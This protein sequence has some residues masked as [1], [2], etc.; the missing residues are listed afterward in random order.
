ML[1]RQLS[2]LVVASNAMV[3]LSNTHQIPPP[4]PITSQDEI[5]Q[6]IGGFNR[7]I[8]IWEQ[9][10]AALREN[11]LRFSEAERIAHLGHWQWDLASGELVCS[12]EVF[13]I[14]E[15]NPAA[16]ART[17]EALLDVIHPDDR[18]EVNRA[19][20]RSLQTRMPYEISHRIR[21]RDGRIKWVYEKCSSDFDPA[22]K[23]LRSMGAMQDITERKAMEDHIRQLAFYDELTGLPNRRLLNDRLRQT[24]AVSKRSGLHGAL[25]FL[26]LDNFKPINDAHGHGIGDLL[27]MEVAR[28]LTECVREVDTVARLGGDEFVVMISELE[29]DKATATEQAHSVAEKILASLAAPYELIATQ[30]GKSGRVVEHRCSASIGVVLFVNHEVGEDELMGHADTAMYQAKKAGRNVVRFYEA[31]GPA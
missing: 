12:D 31:D 22:G 3:T 4:L 16:F 13:R 26:D 7:L 25:M 11:Q 6:L 23:P 24:M 27:L 17:H 10:E 14:L 2:P 30:A 29:L 8:E 18:D 20:A 15:I 28:R 19:Y 1:R 5:G 9:R 21:M